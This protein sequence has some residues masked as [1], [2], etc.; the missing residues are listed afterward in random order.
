VVARLDLDD[1]RE[2]HRH[3][4]GDVGDA[5]ARGGHEVAPGQPGVQRGE[6]LL[7]PRQAA[8]ASAG[9]CG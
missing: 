1:A 6:E 8:L 7:Q 9:I 2:V 3:H 5:E 4:G